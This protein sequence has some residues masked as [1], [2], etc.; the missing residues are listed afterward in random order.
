MTNMRLVF[1]AARGQYDEAFAK[2]TEPM[3]RAAKQ[4]IVEAGDIVKKRGRA[5]I[6]SAGFSERWQKTF[7]V[8]I[9]PKGEQASI[10]SAAFIFH[11]IPY[12]GVFEDDGRSSTISGAPMLW[13]PLKSTPK[14][15]GRQR[16]TADLYRKRIGKLTLI[17]RAGKP[18]L[19]AGTV[20]FAAPT[21]AH[22]PAALNAAGLT[23]KGSGA[24]A[25]TVPLFVGIKTVTLRKRFNIAAIVAKARADLPALYYKRMS[26]LLKE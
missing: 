14:Y 17:K 15:L 25:K 8:N 7:R 20:K 11:K 19:L 18:P 3:A 1:A 26:E 4:A 12:A 9:Y 2:M 22:G 21:D 23:R 6:A 10:K 5:E 16:L 24:F 13:I